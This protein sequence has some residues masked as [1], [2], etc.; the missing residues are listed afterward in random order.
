M[1][2]WKCIFLFS[3]TWTITVASVLSDDICVFKEMFW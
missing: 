2:A 1:S 3:T